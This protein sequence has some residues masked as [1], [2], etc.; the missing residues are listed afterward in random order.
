MEMEKSHYIVRSK[1]EFSRLV[2]A[3]STEGSSDSSTLDDSWSGPLLLSITQ[4]GFGQDIVD[5]HRQVKERF[6]EYLF[7]SAGI[8]LP[9]SVEA[10][11]LYF[12]LEEINELIDLDDLDLDW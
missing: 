7:T 11:D 12:T 10:F 1:G 6:L 5:D 2:R 3:T 4:G 9:R 8:D